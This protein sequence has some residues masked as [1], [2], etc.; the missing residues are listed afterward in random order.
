VVANGTNNGGSGT[1]ICKILKLVLYCE[2]K[3]FFWNEL[4]PTIRGKTII[5]RNVIVRADATNLGELDHI[6]FFV[7]GNLQ[8]N[9]TE[10]PFEWNMNKDY[11]HKIIFEH[12]RIRVTAF[13]KG[14][15]EWSVEQFVHYIHF[16]IL[17]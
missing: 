5:I 3:L 13:Y 9:S 4:F 17:T 16:R 11:Y 12:D 15:C 6:G 14:G 1:S 2:K 10:P 8:Y 7:D